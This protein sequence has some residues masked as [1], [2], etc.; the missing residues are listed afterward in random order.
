VPTYVALLRGV[1]V[2]GRHRMA[3]AELRKRFEALG[4]HAVRTHIQSGN[5][6]FDRARAPGAGVIERDLVETFGFA[7]PV[8][9]RSAVEMGAVVERAP[10]PGVDR[11]KVHV[12]F[13]ASP[14]E[15]SAVAACDPEPFL[16]E[17]F[18]FTGSELYLYLPGGM[19]KTKLPTYLERRIK[20]PM[21]IRNW[22]TTAT[23]ASLATE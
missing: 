4:C 18:A 7:V 16:P 21:T 19:A 9:L 5:V 10:F 23:L 15:P 22:Q 8:V 1:N 13:L 14:P 17:R 20:V 11:S 6:I 3:M 2:G 12:A